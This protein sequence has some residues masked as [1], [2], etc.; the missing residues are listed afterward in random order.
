MISC[1]EL[2]LVDY[3]GMYVP[4]LSGGQ[5]IELGQPHYQHP[6]RSSMDFGPHLDNF[7]SWV[8]YTSL[9]A[10]SRDPALWPRLNADGECL[11]FR[12]SDF[13]HR[14]KSQAFSLLCNHSDAHVR[15]CAR[16]LFAFVESPLDAVPS[17]DCSLESASLKGMLEW[18]KR[19]FL[20]P[21]A[22]SGVETDS[23][24]VDRTAKLPVWID[25]Q[26]SASGSA[27]HHA[28]AKPQL[29]AI[30]QPS[31]FGRLTDPRNPQYTLIRIDPDIF[32]TPA[33]LPAEIRR[34]LAPGEGLYWSGMLVPTWNITS[35]DIVIWRLS[36]FVIFLLIGLLL[37]VNLVLL[38]S[39]LSATL[40]FPAK[41]F[42]LGG[43]AIALTNHRVIVIERQD[44]EKVTAVTVPL[45]EI[46]CVKILPIKPKAINAVIIINSKSPHSTPTATHVTGNRY[47]LKQ[48]IDK[49][50]PPIAV[51]GKL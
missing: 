14:E 20:A 7:S 25:D 3:D 39:L 13:E 30:P 42:P 16:Q 27:R 49:L 29:P 50:P 21:L 4:A 36:A 37:H 22:V 45:G 38:L 10:L 19:S 47:V 43:H 17:L 2:R 51:E 41:V 28:G 32:V 40:L 44:A 46:A 6:Q 11:L 34:Q 35:I 24:P 48:F 9:K 8:I 18:S 12:R 33:H 26:N 15:S 1:D 31:L 5:S 23:G